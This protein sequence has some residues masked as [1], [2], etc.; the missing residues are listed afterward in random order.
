MKKVI[1]ILIF[2]PVSVIVLCLI[3]TGIGYFATMGDYK[4]AKTIEQDRS[5]PHIII[6]NYRFHSLAFGNKKNPIIIALHGGPGNDFRYILPLKNLAD[7][8]YVVFYDQRGAGLSPR[9]P[10][11]QITMESYLED[12]SDIIKFY[13]EEKQ[14]ILIGHS[15]GAM[16][17]AS[18]LGKYPERVS[19][20]VLAEPGILS[21][22]AAEVFMEKVFKTPSAG[23][24]FHFYKSWLK[25]LHVSGPDKYAAKDFFYTEA[26]IRY[27]K[28][29]NPMADYYCKS[30]LPIH[31]LKDWRFGGHASEASRSQAKDENGNLQMNFAKGV[32]KFKKKVLLLSSECNKIIGTKYQKKYHLKLFYKV[33]LKEIKNSGHAMFGE[34]PKDSIKVIRKYLKE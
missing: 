12:L 15:W 2:I 21:N 5:I 23:F 7:K 18:Y 8:Y 29:D 19:K 32:K 34:N 9:V 4:M 27:T 26:L 20:A 3:I 16:L 28:N 31:A 24:L 10:I 11:E 25:S 30:D 14:V 17:A 22:E 6:K 13:A 1:K 33:E